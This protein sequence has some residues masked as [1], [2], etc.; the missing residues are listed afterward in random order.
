[1]AFFFYD[2][3]INVVQHLMEDDSVWVAPRAWIKTKDAINHLNQ[4]AYQASLYS[5]YSPDCEDPIDTVWIIDSEYGFRLASDDE[6]TF[7]DGYLADY[8]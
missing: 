1:M 3:P 6:T 8:S 2:A 7:L 5:I 4:D